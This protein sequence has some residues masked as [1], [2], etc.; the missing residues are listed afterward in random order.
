MDLR[1][2]KQPKIAR[3]F[4]KLSPFVHHRTGVKE[5][6]MNHK[7]LLPEVRT[8]FEYNHRKSFRC[9]SKHLKMV[10]EGE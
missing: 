8:D 10:L 3:T 6:A 2:V 7:P 9:F 1:D 4:Q 5:C